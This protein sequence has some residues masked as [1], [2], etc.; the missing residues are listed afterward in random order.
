[1]GGK[2]PYFAKMTPPKKKKYLGTPMKSPTNAPNTRN[3]RVITEI[4]T[5]IAGEG[6]K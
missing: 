5:V 6:P 4:K 1:M 2:W 3:G